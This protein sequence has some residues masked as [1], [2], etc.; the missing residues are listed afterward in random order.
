MTMRFRTK[1]GLTLGGCAVLLGGTT[2]ASGLMDANWARTR[3]VQAVA[4]KTGRTLRI[5]S[6]HVWLLPTPWI[7]AQGV[8]LTD[9]TPT[10]KDMFSAREI[11]ARVAFGPLFQH[12]V[13]LDNVVMSAPQLDLE[14]DVDGHANWHFTP[15]EHQ[16]TGSGG[17]TSGQHWN[18]SVASLHLRDGGLIWNDAKQNLSGTATLDRVNAK[19]LDGSLVTLDA[20]VHHG[21]GA[22]KLNGTTG[23]LPPTKGQPWPLN[24]D[25]T[26]TASGKPAGRLHVGGV[27]TDPDQGG[28]AMDLQL[29]GALDHL[30]DLETLFPR[31][32]LPDASNLTLQAGLAGSLTDPTLRMVHLRAQSTDLSR[33]LPGLRAD[34]LAIDADHPDDLTDMALNGRL[35][36]L[37]VALRGTLGTPDQTLHAVRKPDAVPLP[38]TLALVNGATSIKAS[39]EVGGRKTS[40]EVHGA[41]PTFELGAGRPAF[42]DLKVDGHV[43]STAPVSS[44]NG[45]DLPALLRSSTATLAVVAARASWQS[46]AWENVEAHVTADDGKLTIDPLHGNGTGTAQGIAQSGRVALDASGSV[47]RLDISAQPLVL[48][49]Q[50]VQGWIGMPQLVNGSLQIVG[51]VTA[52]GD[53][54]AAW[55]QSAV[56][57]VGLSM[58]G[59]RVSGKTLASLIGRGIPVHGN[60]G[61]RCF[62]THM[63]LADGHADLGQLGLEADGLSLSGHGTVDLTNGQL[64]LHLA[65]RIGIGSAAAASPVAVKGTIDAPQPRL[66]PGSDGRFAISIGGPGGSDACPDLLSAA[67]EGG[68]GPAAAAPPKGK[69]GVMDLLKGLLR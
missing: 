41:L 9:G 42:E 53:D 69:G 6:L 14:R 19:G 65:P 59:G 7:S 43:A 33:V 4:E 37:P 10:G 25:L 12:R 64:D 34:T 40:L 39:G 63:Q 60:I 23:P 66:E 55:R 46:V 1:L 3:L 48:P 2:L 22:V 26:F 32:G 44:F 16:S 54:L 67:R 18:V 35:R 49:S 21:A 62:G 57:H 47:P 52:N 45:P 50:V 38:V 8:G 31:A 58:V 68:P 28:T 5:D 30:R 27:V 29:E 51:S 13:V 11:R 61:L 56:G 15:L 17:T 24:A 20:R 36:D